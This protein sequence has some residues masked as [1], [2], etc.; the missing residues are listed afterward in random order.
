MRRSLK[1]LVPALTLAFSAGAVG[2]QQTT[3]TPTT[4]Q[5]ARGAM[6]SRGPGRP[7]AGMRGRHGFGRQGGFMR[8]GNPAQRLLGLRT[9]LGLTSDQVSRLQ[10]LGKSQGGEL[11][12]RSADRL[13][14]RADLLDATRK[15]DLDAAH[16]ALDRLAK[17]R[18]DAMF[19]RLK[20]GKDAQAVLTADQKAK[21]Q[22]FRGA[23]RR[24]MR[25]RAGRGMRRGGMAGGRGF[26][27]RG[28]PGFRMRGGQGFM[29][30][31]P[32]FHGRYMAP[33]GMARQPMLRF[34]PDSTRLRARPDTTR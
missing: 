21:L 3:P 28:A 34:R 17:M 16:A 20:A 22:Q 12:P 33:N 4:P 23:A 9:Q 5:S 25:A 8:A 18:S 24:Q 7:G 15:G 30:G 19:T 1:Y 32:G 26:A 10:A 31:A 6:R 27:R 2:A 29:P 14:A 13:R 11:E